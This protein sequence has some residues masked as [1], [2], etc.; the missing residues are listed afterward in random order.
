MELNA[1]TESRGLIFVW[2]WLT[3]DAECGAWRIEMRRL[4]RKQPVLQFAHEF[5]FVLGGFSAGE[6]IHVRVSGE[7]WRER[8]LGAQEKKGEFFK[9]RVASGSQHARPPFCGGKIF[10]RERK[11][12]EIIFEQQPRALGIGT[13]GE[14]AEDF[15]ALADGIFGISKFAAKIGERTVCLRQ[16]LVVRVVF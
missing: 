5:V 6:A 10:A 11:F 3:E 12:L 2:L 8:T 14:A 7:F 16:N 15:P 4:R 13:G 1:E 9:A